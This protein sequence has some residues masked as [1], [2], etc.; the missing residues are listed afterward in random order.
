MNKHFIQ[1]GIAV[2]VN[3]YKVFDSSVFS[4]NC[5]LLFIYYS[6]IRLQFLPVKLSGS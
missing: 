2:K 1:L 3:C 4:T 6:V 5:L